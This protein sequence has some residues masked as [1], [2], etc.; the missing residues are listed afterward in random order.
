[1]TSSPGPADEQPAEPGTQDGPVGSVGLTAGYLMALADEMH[2]ADRLTPAALSR[3]AVRVLPVDAAGMSVM[4][5]A[6]RLPLGASDPA[7]RIA[8]ELQTALGEGPCL[9]AAEAK[10]LILADLEEL[11][12]RWP[13]YAQELSGQT[14]FRALAAVPLSAPDRGVFA[15]LD[16]Y[17]TDTGLSQR[18]DPVEVEQLASTA[19][20]LLTTCL[21]E[22]GDLDNRDSGPGW[23]REA[24][25]RRQDVWLAIG[26]IMAG[27]HGR[28]S[29]ALSVLRARA[30]AEGI[31]LDNLAADLVAGRRPLSDLDDLPG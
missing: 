31:S 20:A 5:S 11:Q 10:V 15:A 2:G 4:T 26:M 9:E 14:P 30:Y 17:S 3:A 13:L 19:A 24:A 29:D 23:F 16:L 7:S 1:M 12:A 6:L 18:L 28:P 22:V 25:G 27:R 8:E 21:A